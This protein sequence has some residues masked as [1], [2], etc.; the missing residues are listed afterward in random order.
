MRLTTLARKIDKTPNQLIS[1][2]EENNIDVSTGLHGKLESETVELVIN[3]FVPGQ[4]IEEFLASKDDIEI[5]DIEIPEV[6]IPEVETQDVEEIPALDK[7]EI[8]EKQLVEDVEPENEIAPVL[9][10]DVSLQVEE[11]EIEAAIPI[12]DEIK[13]EPKT[14]TV[15]D[16]E[17]EDTDDIEHIKVKKVKLEGIKVV[18]KIDLPK[19]PQKENDETDIENDEVKD[20]EKS[21]KPQSDSKPG[22]RNFSRNRKKNAWWQKSNSTIL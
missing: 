17:N 19:K 4:N 8:E 13:I 6:E 21:E 16:L 12:E 22:N 9:E 15:D 2:L 11:T 18:G 1:F 7:S 10:E 14:G 20:A 3:H 5:P